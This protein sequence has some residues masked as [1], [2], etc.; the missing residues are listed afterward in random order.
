ML[1]ALLLRDYN[2]RLVVLC[3]A[4]LGLACGLAGTFLLLRKRSL[5]G[6]ALSHAM[7]PGIPLAFLASHALGGEGKDRLALLAGAA[8]SG[9]LG[10]LTVVGLRRW[11]RVKDDAAMGVVLSVFFGLGLA[12]LRV[13]EATPGADKAGLDH[14]I[15]GK[16]ASM[17]MEDARWIA[18]AALLALVTS[19][20]LFKELKL[21]CFDESYAA[22]QGWPVGALDLLLMT[23]ITLVTVA[24]LQAVGLILVIALLIT[25]AAA[26]RFWT[27]RL[28]PMLAL[29]AFLGAA[30]GWVGASLSALHANWPAGAV[31]V[32]VASTLFLFSMLLAP[33]RGVVWTLG[34]RLALRRR[35]E[36][37]HLLRAFYELHERTADPA[38]TGRT[39]C[40]TSWPSLLAE[41]SWGPLRL[42]GLLWWA[43]RRGWVS[44][45]GPGAWALT[46]AG[47]ARARALV[48][49][50]RL[51][52]IF[53][54]E[55][56]DIAP[57]HVDRGADRVEHVLA[58]ELI[59][60]LEAL[61]EAR[62]GRAAPTPASPHALG[63]PTASGPSP[64]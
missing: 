43:Q 38:L 59:A 13:A 20:A 23:V 39:D 17:V 30:S 34:H 45:R 29:A 47:H 24:G 50:H 32:L 60:E 48:R 27:Q 18:A 31:I 53:L 7:L 3:T 5:M 2:T 22:S 16:T 36:M 51:W 10:V 1:E 49:N 41:R 55:H 52:E 44:P 63:H 8:A 14:Y 58:P 19:I 46:S 62:S 35:T 61:L 33:S 64:A 28:G 57:S 37:E 54:I 40:V 15:Y 11:T 42:R 25:P 26:A 9:W 21:L 12:L 6:D 4:G 56:A